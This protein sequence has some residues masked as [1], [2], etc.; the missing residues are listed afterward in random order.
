MDPCKSYLGES[1]QNKING[2]RI[3]EQWFC[4]R[5]PGWGIYKSNRD[6]EKYF[7]KLNRLTNAPIKL[8]KIIS[9]TMVY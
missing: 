2:T 4:A 6:S 1:G 5:F 8:S 3:S 7:G 9:Q